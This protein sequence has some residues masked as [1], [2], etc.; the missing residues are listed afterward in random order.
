MAAPVIQAKAW[1]LVTT[2]ADGWKYTGPPADL[3]APTVPVMAA[4]FNIQSTSFQAKYSTA[5]TDAQSGVLDYIFA[6]APTSTGVFV[7]Q[8]PVAPSSAAAG[9]AFTGLDP[10]TSYQVKVKARD[11]SGNVSAYSAVVSATTAALAANNSWFPNWPIMATA[12]I[13]GDSTKNYLDTTARVWCGEKDVIITAW[14]Y[15]TTTRY[16]TRLPG[17]Q[18]LRN[19]YPGCKHVLYMQHNETLKTIS[20]P[21]SDA[22]E[23]VKNMAD[24][25]V[26][27]H[28]SWYLKR[29]SNGTQI[30][31]MFTPSTLWE[32][33]VATLDIGLNSLGERFDQAF[34][35]TMIAAFN[36]SAVSSSY[37][38]MF[39][40]YYDA[41]FLDDFHARNSA[42]LTQNN[43]ANN[44]PVTDYEYNQDG[45]ADVLNKFDNSS[46][47]GGTFYSRGNLKFK[48][49]IEASIL[50]G[51]IPNAARWPYD[52]FDGKNLKPPLPLS[53]H[54]YYG[55]WSVILSE[56]TNNY[57]GIQR[58]SGS[59]TG[60]N[61][62]GV[63]PFG[64]GFPR[65]ALHLRLIGA[66]SASFAGKACIFVEAYG[67][68][69]SSNAFTQDDY[70]LSR[71]ILGVCLLHE[72][73]AHCFSSNKNVP[74]PL[75]ELVVELGNPVGTRSMGTLNE[76]TLGWTTRTAD[77]TSGVAK[78]WWQRFAKGIVVVRLDAPTVG[79]Y[80]SADAAVACTLPAAGSGKKWQM[81]NASTYTS[82]AIFKGAGGALVSR[83]MR[84]QTPTLNNG[85][86]VTTVS[87]KPY[88]AA[89]I[90]L[91][92]GP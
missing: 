34:V 36:G 49:T 7:D 21:Q 85:A 46:T 67:P 77:F 66:D 61:Y 1:P 20:S 10:A 80:P 17:W 73:L 91:V 24:S 75:D 6:I 64:A 9:V 83:S 35:R 51:L 23:L 89:I 22:K 44:V 28:S 45:I 12:Y 82:P 15:P 4:L 88:H 71:F 84:N 65:F 8:T 57:F 26:N 18:F 16:N 13:I 19:N 76:T 11:N 74:M 39:T 32:M 92:N 62:V 78:F 3:T 48:E 54:P 25:A 5:A 27:G 31:A 55:K 56:S 50:T 87:L 81:I 42:E 70:A 37:V 41:V 59:A 47:A 14:F 68:S 2:D 58:N 40:T 38:N 33:N 63:D 86:D 29:A 52:Y 69:R 30:E 79:A 53:N 60:Y 72:G 43:G 90:R